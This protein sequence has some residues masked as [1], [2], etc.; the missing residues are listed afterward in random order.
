MKYLPLYFF[1]FLFFL[2]FTGDTVSAEAKKFQ[3]IRIGKSEETITRMSG[4]RKK[5]AKAP[6]MTLISE[7]GSFKAEMYDFSIEIDHKMCSYAEIVI[8]ENKGDKGFKYEKTLTIAKHSTFQ[9]DFLNDE[10]IYIK[11]WDT[12]SVYLESILNLSSFK[13]IYKNAMKEM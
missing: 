2:L 4:L 8:Y 11:V 9:I 3:K 1:L 10:L 7:H 6:F 5:Y 13:V 12:N